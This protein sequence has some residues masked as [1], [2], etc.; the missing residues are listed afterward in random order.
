MLYRFC[1]WYDLSSFYHEWLLLAFDP[2][3][4]LDCETECLMLRYWDIVFWCHHNNTLSVGLQPW[5][6]WAL[7]M[8]APLSTMRHQPYLA[9][10]QFSCTS[11]SQWLLKNKIFLSFHHTY[12]CNIFKIFEKWDVWQS[13]YN[14]L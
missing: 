1:V 7:G 9:L 8:H 2:S 4:I 3:I 13:I 14:C 5:P 6:E 10:N 11:S 12:V